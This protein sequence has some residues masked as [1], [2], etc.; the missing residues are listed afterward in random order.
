MVTPWLW[1]LLPDNEAVL[2]RWRV[3]TRCPRRRSSRS[4]QRLLAWTVLGPHASYLPNKL[5]R[6]WRSNLTSIGSATRRWRCGFG[7]SKRI[8]RPGWATR[9]A[10]NSAW[11]ELRRKQRFSLKM[12]AG[13]CRPEPWRL[14]TS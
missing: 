2:S 5:K 14:V 8:P 11:P 13:A 10:D 3:I 4:S 12:V 7:S 6:W 1:G 9:S